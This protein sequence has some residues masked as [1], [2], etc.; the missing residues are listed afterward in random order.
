MSLPTGRIWGDSQLQLLI[1]GRIALKRFSRVG[2][3]DVSEES[4]ACINVG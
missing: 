3:A 4:T 1:V 2:R